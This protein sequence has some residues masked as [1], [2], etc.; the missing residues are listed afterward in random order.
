MSY[1][2]LWLTEF[3]RRTNG[4]ST[5]SKYARKG[6]CGRSKPAHMG[7][8]IIRHNYWLRDSLCDLQGYIMGKAEGIM[9]GVWYWSIYVF[10]VL[11][12]ILKWCLSGK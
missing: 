8:D 7:K 2:L 1:L 10:I 11:C 3:Y 6:G 12:L 4:R 5:I 9:V